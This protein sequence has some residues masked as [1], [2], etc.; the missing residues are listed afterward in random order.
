MLP[1]A[2]FAYDVSEHGGIVAVFNLERSEGDERADFL[3]LG[4][5]EESLPR[6]FFGPSE[7]PS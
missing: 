5:C 4:P 6:V 2:S 1:A 7:D 3:F